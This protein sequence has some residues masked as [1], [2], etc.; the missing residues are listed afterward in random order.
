METNDLLQRLVTFVAFL[1]H[2]RLITGG[3][4]LR[5]KVEDFP[6][7]LWE[8]GSRISDPDTVLLKTEVDALDHI[9]RDIANST[10]C[11]C[12]CM[13]SSTGYAF[14]IAIA[15]SISRGKKADASQKFADSLREKWNLGSCG[16]EVL[17]FLNLE[18]QKLRTS[19]GRTVYRHL[20][21]EAV[22]EI[23]QRHSS[24][25]HQRDY[26]GILAS[27]LKDFKSGLLEQNQ[28]AQNNW[29]NNIGVLIAIV[30]VI[31]LGIALVGLFLVRCVM[32]R[33]RRSVTTSPR[34]GGGQCRSSQDVSNS[35][36]RIQAVS[37]PAAKWHSGFD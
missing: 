3:N 7:P 19:A 12:D 6:E 32:L 5:W 2:L 15:K 4:K 34:H 37:T 27:V 21:Q 13:D 11:P 29:Q 17:V 18:H 20:S 1:M 16:E 31:A 26:Y 35:D 9:I 8:E 28:T 30:S 33:R 14:T 25:L 24:L 22:D 36:I 10:G 23:L